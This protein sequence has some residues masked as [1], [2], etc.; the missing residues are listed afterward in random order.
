MKQTQESFLGKTV[1]NVK[2]STVLC[3]WYLILFDF[4]SYNNVNA[5]SSQTGKR[6]LNPWA[7]QIFDEMNAIQQIVWYQARDVMNTTQTRSSIWFIYVG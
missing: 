4:D 6:K 3:L 7:K 5:V 2:C 1:E